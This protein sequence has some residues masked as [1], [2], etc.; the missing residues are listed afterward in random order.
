M[1]ERSILIFEREANPWRKFLADYFMDTPAVLRSVSDPT[2]ASA[3]YDRF[4]PKMLFVES[5]F[6]SR[7]FLQKIKVRRDTDPLFRVYLLGAL[8]AGPGYKDI[9]F[10]DCFMAL[11]FV[12]EFNKR[13]IETLPMPALLRLLVV[14]DEEEVGTMVRDYFGGR[15]DPA[16]EIEYVPDGAK[17][18]AAIARQRPD[19]IILDIKMPVMDGRE[20]YAK[21]QERKLGI[22]VIIFFDSISSEELSE[23][24]KFGNPAVVEKGFQGSSLFALMMLV[25]KQVYFSRD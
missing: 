8:P 10:D 4:L 19:G 7:S 6:L 5:A 22:P 17:A 25:K 16:F 3:L 2:Q 9:A 11:P 12:S 23:I 1:P 14:D 15:K 24:R 21:F 18:L 20:F 13:F